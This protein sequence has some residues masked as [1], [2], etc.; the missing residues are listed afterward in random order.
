MGCKNGGFSDEQNVVSAQLT[1]SLLFITMYIIGLPV[2]VHVKDGSVFSGIFY[3]AS[4]EENYAIV[5]Q[6]AMMTK[7]GNRE[8]NIEKG[9]VVDTLVVQGQDLV[10]VV[11]KGVTIT[12]NGI[13]GAEAT[14][15]K[16]NQS[17]VEKQHSSTTMKAGDGLDVKQSDDEEKTEYG[18]PE[19]VARPV[20]VASHAPFP[21]TV[22]LDDHILEKHSF[23]NSPS[24][25]AEFGVSTNSTSIIHVDRSISS[26]PAKD[27]KLNPEAKVFTPSPYRHVLAIPSIPTV[28]PS[29]GYI[30]DPSLMAA[31]DAIQPDYDVTGHAGDGIQPVGIPSPYHFE[32]VPAY[33]H[34]NSQD[35]MLGQMG[36]PVYLPP[37]AHD[38]VSSAGLSQLSLSP[39]LAQYHLHLHKHQGTYKKQ[40][41]I[42]VP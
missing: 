21:A 31:S 9:S 35:I 11:A 17:S 23:E 39:L 13:V 4:V 10:Q 41:K 12:G 32:A 5:L 42:A 33:M 40:I 19:Y 30:L 3:T 1:D 37:L 7:K 34:Q 36:L 8:V 22:R 20:D 15:T 38:A 16:H 29:I 2:D 28:V 18:G 14:S 26:R 25:K 24:F 6:K 27:S